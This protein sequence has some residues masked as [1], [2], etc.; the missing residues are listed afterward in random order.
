MTELVLIAVCTRRRPQMLAKCLMSLLEQYV[1]LPNVQLQ[2]LV[3]END[4]VAKVKQQSLA[5]NGASPFPLHYVQESNQGLSHA[6]NRALSEALARGAGWLA[7]IDDDEVA[8]PQ[9]ISEL[10]RV[11]QALQADVVRGPVKYH[12]PPEDNWAHLRDTGRKTPLLEGTRIAE[13]ATNNILFS[14][15]LF[16]KEGMN[17]HFDLRLNFTGGEDK[18]FFLEAHTAHAHGVCANGARSRV[19]TLIPLQFSHVMAR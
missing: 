6:R 16:A 12:Y 1:P 3:V 11:A 19:C 10:Y 4:D 14:R 13:G 7:F 5:L 8:E 15:R 18:L 17:L 9:W 2:I